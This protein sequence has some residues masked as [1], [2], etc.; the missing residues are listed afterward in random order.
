[1]APSALAVRCVNQS[2]L[3]PTPCIKSPRRRKISCAPGQNSRIVTGNGDLLKI[4]QLASRV[5][6]YRAVPHLG[7]HLNRTTRFVGILSF[8]AL[9]IP[10]SARASSILI[11]ESQ[12]W[13]YDGVAQGCSACEATVSFELISGTS[14]K[15]SFENTSTDWLAEVNILTGIGFDTD[16]SLQDLTIASQGIE[17]EELE[18][19]GWNW[20][21]Q[22]GSC[23]RE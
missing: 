9:F 22:L 10:S 17:G 8:L 18:T 6:S 15:I 23:A 4:P 3:E 1:M 12:S 16:G 7:G 11:G 14:L 5:Q 20:R 19:V 21:W 2:S 13:T